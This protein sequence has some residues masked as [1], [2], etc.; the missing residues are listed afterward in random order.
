MPAPNRLGP[1]AVR[2]DQQAIGV[3]RSQRDRHPV[4]RL[5]F[6]EGF[7]PDS[8]PVQTRLSQPLTANAIGAITMDD[9]WGFNGP[10][11]EIKEEGPRQL[12]MTEPASGS[13]DSSAP[14]L[15]FP[16]PEVSLFD[17]RISPEIDWVDMPGRAFSNPPLSDIDELHLEAN[18]TGIVPTTGAIGSNGDGA[19]T[20]E[21]TLIGDTPG[22][23]SPTTTGDPA[24]AGEPTPPSDDLTIATSVRYVPMPTGSRFEWEEMRHWALQL[25]T[26]GYVFTPA[27]DDMRG[28]LRSA[29]SPLRSV[30][31]DINETLDVTM[32]PS[33]FL[34]G[35]ESVPA[36][37]RVTVI[38]LTNT[39]D[40]EDDMPV[41]LVPGDGRS[42]LLFGVIRGG[43]P[44]HFVETLVLPVSTNPLIKQV[45]DSMLANDHHMAG[46]LREWDN[47]GA[48][49]A[50]SAVPTRINLVTLEFMS[51]ARQLQVIGNFEEV[52]TGQIHSQLYRVAPYH[53][54]TRAL[55]DIHGAGPVYVLYLSD[56]PFSEINTSAGGGVIVKAE[57][58]DDDL[59]DIT[60]GERPRRAHHDTAMGNRTLVPPA[61][62]EPVRERAGMMVTPSPV[63]SEPGD[64]PEEGD[65]IYAP[66][67]TPISCGPLPSIPGR[68]DFKGVRSSA[69]IY[70]HTTF[71][72][73]F[74][75]LEDVCRGRGSAWAHY[76]I[77]LSARRIA[78]AIGMPWPRVGATPDVQLSNGLIITYEHLANAYARA[79]GSFK[80]LRTF[81]ATCRTTCV[82]LRG[83][84]LAKGRLSEDNK[85]LRGLLEALLAGDPDLPASPHPISHTPTSL[86]NAVNT[87]RGALKGL[88]EAFKLSN[89][90]QS[91]S[92]GRD[93]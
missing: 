81:V 84:L 24:P 58:K 2:P 77:E 53:P 51:P 6:A 86:F 66:D 89:A 44:Q 52:F 67:G 74:G 23:A 34:R 60:F 92:T 7:V 93:E 11:S 30:R 17:G 33:S 22:T 39:S 10:E 75:H 68:G 4:I 50:T 3:R 21:P 91:T 36:P 48:W 54:E 47:D 15:H 57:N 1:S 56:K 8:V 70:L 76:Q 85:A 65:V 73:E 69:V 25:H 59:Q 71:A 42:I 72:V 28:Q 40:D 38:D 19:T 16:L 79:L 45:I 63:V 64:G 90:S 5:T 78:S 83:D 55:N 49:F 29:L 46:V 18:A 31:A 43:S 12:S 32:L 61:L 20:H 35:A 27:T 80:N 14:R 41:R 9:S 37:G 13:V 62:P 82:R 87:S 88:L 26:L